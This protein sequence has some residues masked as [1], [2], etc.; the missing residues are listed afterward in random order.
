[1]TDNTIHY[2]KKN[3]TIAG[4]GERVAGCRGCMFADDKP[5]CQEFIYKYLNDRC[6]YIHVPTKTLPP[7]DI[8]KFIILGGE[9]DG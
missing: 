8:A 5:A 7:E 4:I 1:M 9:K 2:L 6:H 3:D